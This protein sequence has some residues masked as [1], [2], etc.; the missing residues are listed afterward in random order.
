MKKLTSILLAVL[1]VVSMC[2]VG[3]I[4]ATAADEEAFYTVTGTA[5]LFGA[6]AWKE[7]NT[8]FQLTEDPATGLWYV[9][10]TTIGNDG[11]TPI[12]VPEAG[13]GSDPIFSYK[14]TNGTWDLGYNE[15]GHAPG[16]GNATVNVSAYPAGTTLDSVTFILDLAAGKALPARVNNPFV[17]GSEETNPPATTDPDATEGPTAAATEAPTFDASGTHTYTLAGATGLF[18]AQATG[19]GW[20]PSDAAFDLL[21]DAV[22][23]V[24]YYNLYTVGNVEDGDPILGGTEY[25]YKIAAD[26]NWDHS[27]N[28]K[29][30]ALGDGTN[31]VV[32][33][34][35]YEEDEITSVTF[36]F[37]TTGEFALKARYV[38]NNPYTPATTAAAT[39]EA[40]TETGTQAPKTYATITTYDA[41]ATT[42]SET[43]DYLIGTEF[44]YT[45]YLTTE[46]QVLGFDFN[47]FYNQIGQ[48]KDATA[49]AVIELTQIA[50]AT[51]SVVTNRDLGSVTVNAD[52]EGNQ[53]LLNWGSAVANEYLDWTKEVQ[54]YQIGFK[55][56]KAGDVSIWTDLV[57]L[58]GDNEDHTGSVDIAETAIIRS[59]LTPESNY[60]DSSDPTEEPTP[61]PTEGKTEDVT[62]D[63]TE[64]PTSVITSA[65]TSAGTSATGAATAA[66]TAKAGTS[67]PGK[68]TTGDSTSVALLLGILLL[69]AGA[70]VIARRRITD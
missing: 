62:E 61:A 46:E 70:V 42:P 14:I 64:A 27:F 36:L 44:V 55:V 57:Q 24:Y 48:G 53:V 10:V 11:S 7:D 60:V 65:G 56:L 8:A 41:G 25:I 49:D 67:T 23:G 22:A 13:I 2:C 51:K 29:G 16:A 26:H 45:V 59:T 1:L 5:D 43:R 35:E 47:T 18:G 33:L 6:S 40:P 21:Y 20:D 19:Y 69:A 34:F 32:D 52:G 54:V 68:V 66:T 31:A 50:G 9:N 58:L 63:V 30:E 17:P 3:I 4:T 28:D 37:T 12:V 15:E 39:T 38:V